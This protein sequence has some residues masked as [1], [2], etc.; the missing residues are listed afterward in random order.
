[1][2]GRIIRAM[3][4]PLGCLVLSRPPIEAQVEEIL[5]AIA[6]SRAAIEISGDPNRL[7]LPPHWIRVARARSIPFVVSTDAHATGELANL[8]Y[9]V[10]L[11]RRGWVRRQEVLNARD[12]DAFARAVAPVGSGHGP[13]QPADR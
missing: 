1:M 8:R 4:H 2:T 11:A 5:D 12:A 3:R 10:A 9:G 6:D 7:D 13:R